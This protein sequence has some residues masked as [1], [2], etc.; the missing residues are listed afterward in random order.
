MNSQGTT[1]AIL[2]SHL[3]YTPPPLAI[4][5]AYDHIDGQTIDLPCFPVVGMFVDVA[6]YNSR[7]Y[8]IDLA[9]E[10]ALEKIGSDFEITRI[11]LAPDEIYITLKH[12][13]HHVIG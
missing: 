5:D 10:G 7:H 2:T 6:L 13:L 3:G 8:F 4:S 9:T 1:V 11:T 12:P